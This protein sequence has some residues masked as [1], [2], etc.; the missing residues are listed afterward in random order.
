MATTSPPGGSENTARPRP[1]HLGGALGGLRPCS[2][3]RRSEAI[4][5]GIAWASPA[6]WA[7]AIPRA[8]SGCL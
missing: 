6:A 3:R 5:G 2:R 7:S 8:V 1:Q 4:G